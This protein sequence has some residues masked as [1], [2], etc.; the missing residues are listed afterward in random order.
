MGKKVN[1]IAT[2]LSS[3]CSCGFLLISFL[4]FRLVDLEIRTRVQFKIVLWPISW[5][6]SWPIVT[7]HHQ[8]VS[9]WQ[10]SSLQTCMVALPSLQTCMVTL[11]NLQTRMV[12]IANLQTRMATL[13]NLQ[14]CMVMLAS[15]HT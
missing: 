1:G 6:L 7:Y 8:S 11:A 10:G 3:T 15:L 13:P 14:S 5:Y 4:D 2:L 12:T 9:G